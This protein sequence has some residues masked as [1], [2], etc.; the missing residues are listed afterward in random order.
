M[1][2]TKYHWDKLPDE[3]RYTFKHNNEGK[4]YQEGIQNN[5]N[6]AYGLLTT[7]EDFSK[8]GI[9][10]INKAG[11]SDDLYNEMIGSQINIKNNID[12][13]LGWEIIRNLPNNE[14]ALEHEGGANGVQTIIVLLPVSKRGIIIF[15]NGD[16]GDKVYSK[17]LEGSLDIGN[18][19]LK[20]LNQ[21]SYNP[22]QIKTVYCQLIKVHT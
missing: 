12:Q 21:M 14:Y 11:L 3:S 20:C 7:I 18:D 16:E 17:I 6:A 13:G 10:V 22:D 8:F 4:E 19:I 2:D 15:T 9:D 5:A 1:I